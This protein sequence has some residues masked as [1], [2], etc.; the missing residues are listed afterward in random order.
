MEMMRNILICV[1][2]ILLSV[3]LAYTQDLSKYRNF[4]ARD[5]F[6]RNFKAG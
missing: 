6:D 4:S 3:P 5:E 2:A 1:A